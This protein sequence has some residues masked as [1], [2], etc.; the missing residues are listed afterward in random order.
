MWNWDMVAG[1][2]LCVVCVD[3]IPSSLRYKVQNSC[4]M[5][6]VEDSQKAVYGSPGRMWLIGQHKW[7]WD[8]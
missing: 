8:R 1:E 5:A 7:R 3:H 2:K 4:I 6:W